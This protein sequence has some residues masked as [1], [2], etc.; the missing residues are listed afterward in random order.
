M[1]NRWKWRAKARAT[2]RVCPH[3][4]SPVPLKHWAKVQRLGRCRECYVPH[5]GVDGV[6]AG[7]SAASDNRP[8]RWKE[9]E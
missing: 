2:G 5:T 4:K 7:G 3:C 8:V 9:G 6:G 1:F